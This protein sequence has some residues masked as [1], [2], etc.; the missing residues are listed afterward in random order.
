MLMQTFAARVGGI[1]GPE[2]RARIRRERLR[3][4]TAAPPA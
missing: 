2:E 3:W 1:V 4:L